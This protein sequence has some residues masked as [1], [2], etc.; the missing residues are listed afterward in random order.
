MVQR[1]EAGG[2][3]IGG[4]DD[5]HVILSSR[6]SIFICKN[7]LLDHFDSIL[8]YDSQYIHK[9]FKSIICPAF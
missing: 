3:V 5:K 6:T 9:F 1:S 4:N 2:K 7:N 8:F